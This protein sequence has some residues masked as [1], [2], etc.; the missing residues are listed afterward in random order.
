MNS[1]TFLMRI[2]IYSFV[3]CLPILAAIACQGNKASTPSNNIP[4]SADNEQAEGLNI[5]ENGDFIV[6]PAFEIEVANSRQADQLLSAQGE[7]IIVSANF[8]GE[9][10]SESDMDETGQLQLA[11]QDIELKGDT[12]VA[13]FSGIRFSQNAYRKLRDKDFWVLINVISGRKSSED[14]L[15]DCGLME[16]KAS[17]FAGKRF[18]IGCKLIEEPGTAHVTGNNGFPIAC[19]AMPSAE[20]VPGTPLDFLVT[21]AENGEIDWAGQYMANIEDLMAAMRP[22]LAGMLDAGAKK[23]PGIETRGCMMGTGGAIRDAYGELKEDLL[24]KK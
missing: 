1:K 2:P 6:I 21:C 10:K 13:K 22:V 14:N 15:L 16:L 18:L 11:G 23:L 17:Q 8:W 24:N 19:F 3:F 5:S 20:A 12:R 4:R 9:P 7:T